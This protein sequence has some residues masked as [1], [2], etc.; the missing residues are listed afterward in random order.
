VSEAVAASECSRQGCAHW[1]SKN[2]AFWGHCSNTSCPNY[3]EA[4]PLHQTPVAPKA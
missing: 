4:C 1:E 3:M 2:P